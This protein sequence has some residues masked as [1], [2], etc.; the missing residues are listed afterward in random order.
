M[1]KVLDDVSKSNNEL[2]EVKDPKKLC[3]HDLK[4]K[5]KTKQKRQFIK[6]TIILSF[7]ITFFG[8]ISL[9]IYQS[10]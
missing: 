3:V 6:N 10:L 2:N 9:L 4:Q 1:N 8:A 5:L 7:I